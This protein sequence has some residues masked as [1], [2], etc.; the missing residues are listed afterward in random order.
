MTDDGIEETADADIIV[1][2][3]VEVAV[4]TRPSQLPAVL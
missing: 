4:H 3:E 2:M 1:L